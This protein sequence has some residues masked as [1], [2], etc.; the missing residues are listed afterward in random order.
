MAS[1]PTS[2]PLAAGAM[3]HRLRGP[4]IDRPVLV[5]P[6]A[7][8]DDIGRIGLLALSVLALVVGVVTGFGAV[9]FRDLIGLLHNLFFGQFDFH[10][11][12]NIFTPASPWGALVI[13]VPVIGAVVVT[14]LVSNFAPEAQGPRR[15]GGDGRHL[16]P[17]R[18]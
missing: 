14:F 15:A 8:D 6:E 16:L 5:A 3:D 18:A 17:A 9:L 11:D 10:Y 4:G 12:A 1:E 13:L 7:D 2:E